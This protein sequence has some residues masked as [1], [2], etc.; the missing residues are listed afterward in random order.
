LACAAALAV[1][2]VM[3][4]DNLLNK[5][6]TNGAA[7]RTQLERLVAEFPRQV[8]AIAGRGYMIGMVLHGEPP[9]FI[10]ALREEGL[11]VV[12]AGGNSVRLL[13][14]LIA[15]KEHLDRATAIIRLVLAR[16]N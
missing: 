11:L 8:K 5:V 7:W 12:A 9:P 2:D 4:R 14:P 3:E 10:T 16:K 6:Q 1:L 13:P 15:T